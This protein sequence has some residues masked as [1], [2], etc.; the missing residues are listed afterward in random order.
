VAHVAYV[1]P[2][3]SGKTIAAAS[4][5]AGYMRQGFSVLVCDPLFSSWDCTWQTGDL[6]EFVAF[7]KKCRRC[8]LF[9]DE[10][11]MSKVRQTAAADWLFS[12]ARHWGHRTHVLCQGGKQLD[13]HQRGQ[14]STLKIFNCSAAVSEMWAECFNDRGIL[15]A[16][17]LPAFH[18][19]LKRRNRPLERQTVSLQ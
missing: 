9:V 7:A 4:D 2:T 1:G 19:L 14:C 12:T 13:P 3:E 17:S 18:Y 15:L 5:A 6:E 16:S 11:G 10:A 8:A